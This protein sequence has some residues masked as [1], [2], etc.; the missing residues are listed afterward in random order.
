M[1]LKP[2]RTDGQPYGTYDQ[3]VVVSGD[4]SQKVLRNTYLMLAVTMVPTAIGAALGIQLAPAMMASP[5][6]TLVLMLASVI[7]LQFGIVRFRNSAIGIGLL[8][9]MTFLMGLFL[10]PLLNVA[11][12]MR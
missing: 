1:E 8:L 2:I 9:L 10:G 4:Q 7:G 6:I 5:I 11:L 12:S 3:E